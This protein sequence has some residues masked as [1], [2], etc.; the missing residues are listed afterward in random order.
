MIYHFDC[1]T[2]LDPGDAV[3]RVRDAISRSGG[4]IAE[5]RIDDDTA[6]WFNFTLRDDRFES[7]RDG[8]PEIAVYVEGATMPEQPRRREVRCLM[9]VLLAG[10]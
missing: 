5:H 2:R 3:S 8:L 1:M 9:T 6:A 7:F 10:E 4:R